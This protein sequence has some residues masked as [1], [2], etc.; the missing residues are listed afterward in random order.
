[1]PEKKGQ[2]EMSIDDTPLHK[3]CQRLTA[4]RASTRAVKKEM[5]DAVEDWC[6]E[7]KAVKKL[8]IIHQGGVIQFVPGK[9]SG[10]RAKFCNS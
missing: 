10:D 6:N 4:A 2:I 5:D 7:M 3:A 1:M 9:T 8:K